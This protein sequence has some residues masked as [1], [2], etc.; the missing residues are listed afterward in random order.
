MHGRIRLIT[1]RRCGEHLIGL[2]PIVCLYGGA[3]LA[4]DSPE[5]PE[6]AI[7]TEDDARRAQNL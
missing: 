3:R 4:Q 5:D 6:P 2:E 7:V 1:R